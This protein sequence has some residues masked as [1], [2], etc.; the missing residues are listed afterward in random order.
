MA[1]SEAQVRGT[2]AKYGLSASAENVRF[3]SGFFNE[4]IPAFT[5]STEPADAAPIAVLRVDGNSYESCRDSLYHLC[6]RL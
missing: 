5:R 4:T 3:H 6:T 2:F 1:T